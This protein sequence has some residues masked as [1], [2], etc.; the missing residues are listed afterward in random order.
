M[1]RLFGPFSV[2]R[3]NVSLR[4]CAFAEKTAGAVTALL[5]ANADADLRKSRRF[6]E[7]SPG[8]PR[9]SDETVFKR[10]A[11]SVR[12]AVAAPK[13]LFGLLESEEL[14]D[15]ERLANSCVF[16]LLHT[17]R[18]YSAKFYAQNIRGSPMGGTMAL[19]LT[20]RPTRGINKNIS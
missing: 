13:A 16:R 7:N 8:Q 11:R 3:S 5:A 14:A 4:D 18:I 12:R 6:I 15:R 19:R 17:M 9:W 2:T 10:R 20:L 1:S